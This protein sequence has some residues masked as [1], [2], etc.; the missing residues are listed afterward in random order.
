MLAALCRPAGAATGLG[1]FVALFTAGAI[2]S[3]M[4][5]APMCGPFVLAQ[6]SGGLRRIGAAQLCERHRLTQGLLLPYHCGR[7]TTYAALGAI[8]AATGAAAGS[9]PFARWLPGAMLALGAALFV[10]QAIGRIAPGWTS[11]LSLPR[12]HGSLLPALASRI[13]R[14]RPWGGYLLGVLLGF[15]P[16]GLLYAALAIASASLSAAAGAAAMAAFGLGTVPS[17]IALGIAGQAGGRAWTRL[18]GTL[19]PAL[20][21]LNA[22]L[23]AAMAIQRL[24][25][26]G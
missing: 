16:C 24:S 19:G 2:G 5:C 4:H 9:L 11:R 22:L 18:V 20:L 1:L 3:V 21:L 10:A 6:V 13:D 26:P 25:Q 15:L 7:L 17:L 14:T 23:L 12:R 8:A